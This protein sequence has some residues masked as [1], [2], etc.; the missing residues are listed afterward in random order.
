MRKEKIGVGITTCNRIDYFNQCFDSIDLSKIDYLVIVNDGKP[1]EFKSESE[2]VIFIQN[3]QNLG[4]GRTKNKIF[5]KLLELNC[6]HIFT[7][8][9]DCIIADNSVFEEYIKA[10]KLTGL[11]HFNFGPGSPWN[12]KQKDQSII[13]DLSKRQNAKFFIPTSI[14][15]IFIIILNYIVF[16]YYITYKD[17]L[18]IYL[19]LLTF[20]RLIDGEISLAFNCSLDK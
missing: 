14:D 11:R 18:I 19:V 8:E 7:L 2:K 20:A 15:R 3:E 4:V 13:G 1:F 12:R 9:D 16:K 5:K 17:I 10:S 6:D